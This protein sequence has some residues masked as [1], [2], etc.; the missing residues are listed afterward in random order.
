MIFYSFDLTT[1]KQF[2]FLASRC[3]SLLDVEQKQKK[4]TQK[5]EKQSAQYA[6]KVRE[7]VYCVAEDSF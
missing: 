4:S 2:F 5:K 3:K 7:D 1:G 6:F